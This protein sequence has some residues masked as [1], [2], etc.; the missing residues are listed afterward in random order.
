MSVYFCINEFFNTDR[1]IIVVGLGVTITELII[2]VAKVQRRVLKDPRE[3]FS[4]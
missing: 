4:L 1:F 3:I 2:I